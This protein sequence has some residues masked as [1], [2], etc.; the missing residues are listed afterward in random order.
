MKG[1]RAAAI[2]ALILHLIVPGPASDAHAGATGDTAFGWEQ[3]FTPSTM[4]LF[5]VYGS[6]SVAAAVGAGGTGLVLDGDSWNLVPTP[7]Q[8]TLEAVWAASGEEIFAVGA[9]GNIFRFG[10]DGDVERMLSGTALTLR[11][12]W[13]RS[14]N[15]VYAAGDNGTVLHFDGD[16]W[17]YQLV[18]TVLRLRGIAGTR[19]GHVFTVGDNGKVFRSDGGEWTLMQTGTMFNLYA[20]WALAEDAVFAVGDGGTILQYDG[21]GWSLM[22]SPTTA[23]LRGVWGSSGTN[24]FAVG[25]RGTVL[26]YDG[27]EW[28]LG[29]LDTWANLNAIANGLIVGDG[30]V[31]FQNPQLYPEVGGLRVTEIDAVNGNVEVTNTGPRFLSGAHPFC[32]LG[33]C[34]SHIPEGT[35]FL[36]GGILVFPVPGLNDNYSDLWLYRTMPLSN[37]ENVVHGLQYGRED[38]LGSTGVAV[39]A[40]KW[41]SV[42]AGTPA[43]PLRATVAYDGFGFSPADWYVDETP[44]MGGPNTTT[45]GTVATSLEYPLGAQTFED[46]SLGDEVVAIRGWSIDDNNGVPGMFTSHVV[47]DVYGAV[48][49]TGK[50]KRWAR[51]RDQDPRDAVNR[52]FTPVIESAEDDDFYKWTVRINIEE[53]T[54]PSGYSPRLMVQH[55]VE[56]ELLKTHFL[57]MWGVEFRADAVYLV[58]DPAGGDA[59]A[60]ALYP[61]I[62]PYGAGKW[63]TITLDVNLD[64][65][66]IGAFVDGFFKG[67]LPIA[68]TE[69]ADSSVF[70]L[71]YDGDGPGNVGT[72]LLDLVEVEVLNP[73]PSFRSVGAEATVGGAAVWWSFFGGE[74]I[75]GFNVYRRAGNELEDKIISGN[76]PLPAGARR[77]EDASILPEQTYYY[78]VTALRPDGSEVRSATAT[79]APRTVSTAMRPVPYSFTHGHPNPFSA[80]TSFHYT[81][82]TSERVTVRVYDVRGAL[83]STLE[84]AVRAE[85]VHSVSWDGRDSFGNVVSGGTYFVELRSPGTVLTRKIVLVR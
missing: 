48:T 35:E 47:N 29:R 71:S 55:E 28:S 17:A 43:A 9:S 73:G 44:T 27:E 1:M 36:A 64:E 2:A 66:D 63:V 26:R 23:N 14:A 79:I 78:R 46:V 22:E 31:V 80:S 53:P 10:V 39:A 50:S 33:D 6:G 75:D 57:D 49:T 40:R 18:P 51:V 68:P 30:G 38:D 11:W 19:Q 67:E 3:V 70:R 16:E 54:T 77:F 12:V 58:V 81:L 4:N 59:D 7:T 69:N 76:D 62:P 24:I 56:T 5:G 65:G 72:M 8:L 13:G 41:P 37:P 21:E 15:D 45:P 25:D 61:L 85:G 32:H 52:I 74:P 42:D 20:V 82:P 34:D 83:V 60:V 84:D